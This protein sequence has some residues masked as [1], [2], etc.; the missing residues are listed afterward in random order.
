VPA[1]PAVAARGHADDLLLSAH[2]RS[3]SLRDIAR[4]LRLFDQGGR[5][6]VALETTRFTVSGPDLGALTA[7]LASRPVVS[8]RPAVLSF[9]RQE[10]A[11]TADWLTVPEANAHPSRRWNETRFWKDGTTLVARN[12]KRAEDLLGLAS[13]IARLPFDLATLW[14]PFGADWEAAGYRSPGFGN[15]HLA[16]GW[17]CMFKGAGH[18]HLVSRR[19]LEHGPWRVTRYPEDVS[20]VQFYDIDA[21]DAAAALAQAR[22]GHARLGISTGGGFIQRNHPYHHELDG[23]YS[24]FTRTYKIPVALRELPHTEMLDAC[25]LRQAKHKDA[26]APIDHVGFVFTMGPDEAKPYRRDLWL[27]DLQCW[28]V[29]DGHEVRLDQD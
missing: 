25:A 2:G 16:H 26:R 14:T 27:R 24:P 23:L 3:L 6:A 9:D 29:V 7:A 1:P 5:T 21:P 4:V 11:I 13:F 12:Q 18:D 20:L 28:A 22:P 8:G 15:G 17:A 19:W 10:K